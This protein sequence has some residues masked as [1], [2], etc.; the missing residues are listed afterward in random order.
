MKSKYRFEAVD[1][2]GL[3]VLDV[4]L[5]C[6][7]YQMQRTR[8]AMANAMAMDGTWKSLRVSLVN[9][10]GERVGE[11]SQTNFKGVCNG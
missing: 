2:Q 6:T 4:T 7:Q 1:V 9:R 11:V 8:D 10:N 3:A 5:H